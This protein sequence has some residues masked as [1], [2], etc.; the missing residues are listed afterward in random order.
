MG[1]KS[2]KTKPV[3]K[4]DS[5]TTPANK[6]KNPNHIAPDSENE[7]KVDHIFKICIIG[8]ADV[9]KTSILLRFVEDKFVEDAKVKMTEEFL[10]KIIEHKGDMVKLIIV[11]V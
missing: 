7:D 2:S 3:K 8:D 5:P 9:G 11:S 4:P 6:Q 10:T 1:G